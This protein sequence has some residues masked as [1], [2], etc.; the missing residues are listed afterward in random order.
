MNLLKPPIFIEMS[1]GDSAGFGSG[2]PARWLQHQPELGLSSGDPET[3][4]L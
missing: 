1:R 2:E 3:W 4:D